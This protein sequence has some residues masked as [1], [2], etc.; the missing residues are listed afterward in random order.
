MDGF[1]AK[2]PGSLLLYILVL[3]VQLNYVEALSPDG[4]IIGFELL[5]VLFQ[6][7]RKR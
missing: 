1:L 6:L 7:L 5:I 4:M 3:H 2:F